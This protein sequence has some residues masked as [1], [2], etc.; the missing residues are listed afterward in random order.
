METCDSSFHCLLPGTSSCSHKGWGWRWG[1]ICP[2][3][4]SGGRRWDPN[5]NTRA[6]VALTTPNVTK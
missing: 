3:A 1:M 5:R 4:E 6:D 2:G